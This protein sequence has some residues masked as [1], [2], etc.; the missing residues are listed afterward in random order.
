MISSLSL[1][2]LVRD[3]IADFLNLPIVGR[4]SDASEVINIRKVTL[5][6][7]GDGSDVIFVG[8]QKMWTG[9]NRSVY[10]VPYQRTPWGY[11]RLLSA[12]SD[13]AIDFHGG[14]KLNVF[15]GWVIKQ[16]KEGLL[17]VNPTYEYAHDDPE[18][19]LPVQKF[20]SCKFY[21]IQ[22]G[23]LIAT[24][25][26]PLN[27]NISEDKIFYERYFG[28]KA[29]SRPIQIKNYSVEELKRM[30]YQI[31]NWKQ[32]PTLTQLQEKQ[33]NKLG[34]AMQ[35]TSSLTTPIPIN[36]SSIS[37]DKKTQS[38]SPFPI[39]AIVIAIVIAGMAVFLLWRKSS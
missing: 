21:Q 29:N 10:Y 4:F 16:H 5:D 24:E 7:E 22:N 27:L 8:H 28:I 6:L 37:G 14:N 18:K 33:V 36:S 13:M 26:G 35:P 1:A 2:Q 19:V 9:D 23:Q 17:I 32:L 39:L 30:G 38:S 11:K 12:D 15:V 31:P 34:G 3:P 25:L 20:S